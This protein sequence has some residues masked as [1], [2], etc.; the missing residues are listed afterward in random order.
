MP[1]HA[2]PDAAPPPTISRRESLRR[3]AIIALGAGLGSRT[4]AA[5]AE[6]SP[7][8][9]A[10]P[11]AAGR[12]IVKIKL[13]FHKGETDGGGLVGTVALSPEIATFLTSPLGA[14]TI[15]KFNDETALVGS[16]TLSPELTTNL[17]KLGTKPTGP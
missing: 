8:L 2:P 6:A 16:T 5:M 1:D 7:G 14:R 4:Q 3:A 12:L 9:A 13:S 10:D 17:R 11:A 15:L